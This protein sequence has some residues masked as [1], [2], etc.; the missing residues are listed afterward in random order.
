MIYKFVSPA[1]YYIPGNSVTFV[2]CNF[3]YVVAILRAMIYVFLILFY[4]S[5]TSNDFSIQWI[6]KV[7]DCFFIVS[8]EEYK[9]TISIRTASESNRLFY[10]RAPLENSLPR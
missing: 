5:L 2:V 6:Y 8:S 3:T 1:L 7:N 10:T 4:S 9:S